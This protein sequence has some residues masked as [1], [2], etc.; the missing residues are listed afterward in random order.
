MQPIALVP[1][2]APVSPQELA[3]VAS[4]I[5]IQLVRD[6]GPAWHTQSSCAA[7]PALQDVPVGYAVVLV[8]ADAKGSAGLH[9]RPKFPDEP[10]FALVQYQPKLT[11]SIAASHEVIELLIDPLGNRLFAGM[12]PLNPGVRV[13]YLAEICDPCQDARCAYQVDHQHAVLVSDFCL[14]AFYG[15]EPAAGPYSFRRSLA[16]PFSVAT[17]GYLSWRE[18]NGAWFQLRAFGGP[19]A[20]VGPMTEQDVLENVGEESG[21]LRG[22][23]DRAY[24]PHKDGASQRAAIKSGSR[25]ATIRKR[26]AQ[27]RDARDATLRDYLDLLLS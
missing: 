14:P 19:T 15:I 6:V 12:H 16:T 18:P 20:V 5:Q 13:D 8:V 25:Y 17:G 4:A 26:A 7:F 23:L 2:G 24:H 1:H 22:A 3:L 11:W 9:F 21:N 27:Q 10:P